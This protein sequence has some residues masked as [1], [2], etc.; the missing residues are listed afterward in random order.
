MGRHQE[1]TRNWLW[2]LPSL[3]IPMVV[4]AVAW[5]THVAA[6]GREIAPNVSFAGVD[7]SGLH[8]DDARA[9]VQSRGEEFLN[10]PVTIDFG[11]RRIVTDARD[12]GFEYDYTETLASVFSARHGDGPID[13]FAAWAST[14]FQEVVVEDRYHL[15]ESRATARL[16]VEDFVLEPPVEPTITHDPETG[17]HLAPGQDGL[18]VDIAE[19]IAALADSDVASGAVEI[20]AGTDPIPPTVPDSAVADL[21]QDLN[22]TTDHGQIAL[23]A[24][25]AKTIPSRQIR[26][27][28]G[29]VVEDGRLSASV[30]LE[31]LQQEIEALFPDPI[32]D[33]VPPVLEVVDGQVRVVEEGEAPPV[34]C[35]AESVAHMAEAILG[36]G[37]AFYE[38]Q[39]RPEDDPVRLAWADGSQIIE[40]VSEFTTNHACC[41]NRVANIQT[42]ADAV[43]GVYIVPGQTFSLNDF[44][45]PRTRAK[46]YLPAGAIRGGHMT[47]EIGGGVSQFTTTLFNAA[48]FAGLDL[49]E[50]QSHSVYFSRY[51]FGREATLSMPGP[52]LVLTNSTD[53]PIL[54]WPT[55]DATSITVTMYSTRNVEVAELDQRI[56]FRNQ[57]RQS[58]IDR[59]RTFS[60][61]RVVVDTIVAFYRP[62]DGLDCNGRTIPEL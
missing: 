9:V 48:Y 18:G 38:L 55:Y 32:G 36:G 51:P 52:D 59:Q 61:G 42:M 30:D 10:T 62:G 20:R 1:D 25:T 3:V 11:D 60:D 5:T 15:D 21:A 44:I 8:P 37:S 13:E 31:G 22:E 23:L 6:E 50:Y 49:D 28:L 43:R 56:S 26:N 24:G 46:G 40:P 14:P 2:V 16:A 57:C 29:S 47:D 27:H 33:F 17:L 12:I 7:V 35:S 54:I 39:T 58:A 53:Y 45:G 34:C 41:E 19:V 4:S